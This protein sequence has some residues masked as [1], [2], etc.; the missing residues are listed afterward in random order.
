MRSLWKWVHTHE[1][2]LSAAAMVLGFIA[3]NI[4]FGRVDHPLTHLVFLSYLVIAAASIALVHYLESG[5]GKAKRTWYRST[6][7]IVT[8]LMLGGLWSALLIFYS[9]SA[10]L[11]ASWP[12]LFVLGAIFLGNEIFKKYHDQLVFNTVLYFFGLYS[13]AIFALPLLTKQIGTGTFLLS[14]VVAV[15]I[16][17]IFM[18]FLRRL[19]RARVQESIWQIR[20]FAG[21]VFILINLFYFTNILPPLPLALSGSGIYHTLEHRSTGYFVTTESQP[22]YVHLGFDPIMHLTPG[23]TL[24]AYSAVF[25][26]ID[27]NTKILHV[28]QWYDPSAKK[29]VTD[30]TIPFSISGGRE[31]GYRVYSLRRAPQAGE[32]RVNIE[33]DDGRL[34]GRLDFVVDQVATPVATAVGKLP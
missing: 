26:P 1:T 20:F 19:G 34:I 4:L 24:Y 10:T 8:Q 11:A 23:E 13:Y 16:F 5:Q 15:A 6:L 22:W 32:W 3:D 9:R 17:A 33:T 18:I 28:W 27:L 25:A 7:P 14:D 31:G 21:I 2:H 12:F 30:F 29:W